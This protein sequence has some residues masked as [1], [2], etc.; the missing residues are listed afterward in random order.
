MEGRIDH[1]TEV[2]TSDTYCH[3]R[4]VAILLGLLNRP[5]YGCPVSAFHKI[6]KR[7]KCKLCWD[8]ATNKGY[9]WVCYSAVKQ[10]KDYKKK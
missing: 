4:G 5:R 10:R 8:F 1:A 2:V 3:H 6:K 7:P 9:C